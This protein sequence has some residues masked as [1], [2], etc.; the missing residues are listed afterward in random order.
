M[1][2]LLLGG[3]MDSAFETPYKSFQILCQKKTKIPTGGY[4]GLIGEYQRLSAKAPQLCTSRTA[5]H[6]ISLRYMKRR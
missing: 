2:H 3:K 1:S 5:L 6:A 4:T